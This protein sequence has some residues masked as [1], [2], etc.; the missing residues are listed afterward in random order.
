MCHAEGAVAPFHE[1]IC[2]VGC[3]DGMLAQNDR[4]FLQI[5]RGVGDFHLMERSQWASDGAV[6]MMKAVRCVAILRPST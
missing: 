2:L 5:E 3:I 4:M 6:E 1:G